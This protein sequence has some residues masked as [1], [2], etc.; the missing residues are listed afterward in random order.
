MKRTLL[1]GIFFGVITVSVYAQPAG[2]YDAADGL[3]EVELQQA[4]HDIIDNH[5]VKS[6]TFLWTAFRT[7]DKKA[8]GFVWDMYSDVPGGDPPYDYVFGY[9]SDG[10]DQCGN[11][12][13]EG[14]C[15]NR[16][17]SFPKS[18]F[19]GEIPPM[20]S[21]LFHLYPT[22]GSVN[23]MR[24]NLPFGETDDNT[25]VSLNG[26]KVGTSSVEGYTGT[27]FEP[28]DEYKGDFARTYFYMATRYYGDEEDGSWPGSGMVDGSQLK[29]WAETM[30]LK[31]HSD[32]PVS[33]KE[34][35]SNLGEEA[36]IQI[37]DMSGRMISFE[38]EETGEQTQ[39]SSSMEPGIYGLRISIDSEI[40]S[41]NLIVY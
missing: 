35:D 38:R 29:P 4:L 34:V 19:G 20:T 1:L 9:E 30:M 17:H 26:C 22:D 40:I 13:G 41:R 15:Y 25:N 39:I 37:F 7:T 18:W 12:S 24:G 31:W 6:Y 11:Y 36:D 21:D 28:I 10:G 16:E 3:T 5:T 14:S 23:G 2:Y 33:T 8:N 32:D 27:V